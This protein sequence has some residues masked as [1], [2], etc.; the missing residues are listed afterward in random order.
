MFCKSPPLK[1]GSKSNLDHILITDA[2]KEFVMKCF[3]HDTIDNNSDHIAI[4]SEIELS[5]E[6]LAAEQLI[7]K[8]K[9]A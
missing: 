4:L 6:Y 5:N 9:T 8:P 1:C 2:M 7:H 3:T